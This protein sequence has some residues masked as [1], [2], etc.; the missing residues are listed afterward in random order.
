MVSIEKNVEKQLIVRAFEP[1]MDAVKQTAR[2]LANMQ[3]VSL[4]LYGQ[5]GEVLIVITVRAFAAAAA[6]ELTESV[7]EQFE[8]ALGSAVYGRG[9]AN[10][11]HFAAGEMIQKEMV[12]AAA[13]S[14]TGALLDEEFRQTKRGEHVYDFGEESYRSTRIAAKIQKAEERY[15]YE[16]D[17]AQIAAARAA[18]AAKYGRAEIGAAIVGVDGGGDVYA[19]VAYKK[20]VYL[21]VYPDEPGVGKKAALAL[22][23]MARVL[24]QGREPEKAHMFRANTDFDWEDPLQKRRRGASIAPIIA[25]ALLLLALGAACWYFFTH[26][27]LGGQKG[28]SLPANGSSVTTGVSQSLSD[29][30][31]AA[32]GQPDDS[33]QPEAPLPPADGTSAP[34]DGQDAS[35]PPVSSSQSNVGIVNPFG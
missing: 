29:T 25:L 24:A 35:E 15:A 21:R 12:M 14:A 13:D 4:N 30:D 27:S 11:A 16:E 5:A 34:E 32:P 1:D 28:D 8:I 9:K 3:D 20:Y 7:A 2:Q 10:L 19:A 31:S 23:D 17:P 6:T 26:F 18:A 22:L 33:S